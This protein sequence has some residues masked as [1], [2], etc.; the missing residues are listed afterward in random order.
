MNK[1]NVTIHKTA[2]VLQ[3]LATGALAAVASAPALIPPPYGIAVIAAMGALQ[4][5]MP[6]PVK[7]TPQPDT[8]PDTSKLSK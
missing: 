2:A 5:L 6:S 8:D 4:A 3:V 1:K 7:R